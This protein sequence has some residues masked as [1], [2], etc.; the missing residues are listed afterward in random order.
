MNNIN[1]HLYHTS[2]PTTHN[3]PPSDAQTHSWIKEGVK[4]GANAVQP[5]W[6]TTMPPIYLKHDARANTARYLDEKE[7]RM[8]RYRSTYGI[9]CE[10]KTN[11]DLS[12]ISSEA[13]PCL[14]GVCLYVST[15]DVLCTSQ[16]LFVQQHIAA[17]RWAD[18]GRRDDYAMRRLI[19]LVSE[20]QS[21][22]ESWEQAWHATAWM[23]TVSPR[24]LDT[25][26]CAVQSAWCVNFLSG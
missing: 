26:V 21:A 10:G 3:R 11:K 24:Y 5:P 14:L 20:Q 7:I 1:N 13:D 22:E 12:L 8:K 17:S 4:R 9:V 23:Y 6:I 16:V 2:Q 25:H 18:P 19:G 15:F